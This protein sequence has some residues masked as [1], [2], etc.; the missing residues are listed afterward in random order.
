[1]EDVVKEEK[2]D[3]QEDHTIQGEDPP[4]DAP[5]AITVTPSHPANSATVPVS[6]E[7]TYYDADGGIVAMLLPDSDAEDSPRPSAATSPTTVHSRIQ[8]PTVTLRARDARFPPTAG[9][10]P[11]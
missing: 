9:L 2:L 7:G 11:R 4:S 3:L 8:G 6:Q 10:G 1:M 5:T